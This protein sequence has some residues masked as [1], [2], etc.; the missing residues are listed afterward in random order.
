MWDVASSK[1]VIVASMWMVTDKDREHRQGTKTEN[2]DMERRWENRTG[3]QDRKLRQGTKM[4]NKDKEKR[5]RL[6]NKE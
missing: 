4:G 6:E 1:W 5:L 2:E 3:N